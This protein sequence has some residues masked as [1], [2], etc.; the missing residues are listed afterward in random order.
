MA[1]FLAREDFATRYKANQPIAIT[2]LLYPLLQAYDSIPIEADVEM[3]GTDQKFNLLVGRDLQ[4]MMGLRPQQ[5]FLVPLLVGT[6]GVKKMSQSLGNY[7]GVDEAPND[8]YGKTMSLPDALIIPYF[9]HLTD[10]PDREVVEMKASMEEGAVNPMDLKKRLARELVAQ[11]HDKEAS[12]SAERYFERTVQHR[13]VPDDIASYE[14]PPV[15]ELAGKRRSD[16][17]VDAGLAASSSEARR[18]IGQAAVK[19]NDVTIETNAAASTFQD[20][21]IVR[22]GRRRS[23]K[24]TRPDH[25][26]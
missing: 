7:I 12:L 1:Q 24:I 26:Q 15:S 17:L 5:C 8:M 20:G 23:V 22:V 14:L 4:Q 3:G 25:P 11:F 6:D 9:D 16:I 21:D 13:E 2:E 19:V 18:L 10:I